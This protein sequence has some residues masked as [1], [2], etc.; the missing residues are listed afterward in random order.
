MPQIHGLTFDKM[1]LHKFGNE[2]LKLNYEDNA[3]IKR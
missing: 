2:N 1:F 3:R